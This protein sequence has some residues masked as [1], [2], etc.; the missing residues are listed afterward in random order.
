MRCCLILLALL[1]L[2]GGC[3]PSDGPRAVSIVSG[4]EQAAPPFAVVTLNQP[5]A[6]LLASTKP[7]SMA[8][9][10]GVGSP[11]PTLTLGVGDIVEVTIF[12][13]AS[14]GLFSGD[15]GAIGATKSVSLPPQPISRSGT[16]SVPYVGQVRAA[17][18]TPAE[19][20]RAVEVALKNK[21]IE[22]QVIVT[23][24]TSP[25][26]F[27]TVAGDVGNPGQQPLN[28]GG[29]RMLNVIAKAGGARQADYNSLVRLTRGN[30]TV[31]VSLAR[32]LRDPAQNIYLRP[33]DLVY[34]SNDPQ[35]FTVFGATQRTGSVPFA[36]DHMTLI[37]ALG[38]AGGLSDTRADARSVFVFRYEDPAIYGQVAGL[39]PQMV[40]SPAPTGNGVP[41]V[42]RI[43]MKD[44]RSFFAAQRFP[45]RSNDVL[46]V[47]NAG[48]VDLQ[49]L[50]SV[51]TGSVGGV[52]SADRLSNIIGQ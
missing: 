50:L 18:L 40:G 46:Y 2:L 20:Q 26:T 11:A 8:D 16:L 15:S 49:K 14:G 38:L 23:V 30:S 12:E 3:I 35:T 29:D 28:L 6:E 9:T 45:M 31:T 43:D 32:I 22:P 10:F 51:F 47:S 42:Y 36:S 13:A 5:V 1:P 19:V 25:S 7:A 52:N 41:V 33:N 39:R 4:G 34:V 21:A 44:P 48:A 37:D 24:V 17:G 27:V